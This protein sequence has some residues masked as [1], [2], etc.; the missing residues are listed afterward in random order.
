GR[1]GTGR[2]GVA[3]SQPSRPGIAIILPGRPGLAEQSQR[4]GIQQVGEAIAEATRSGPP[5]PTGPEA[6]V[7]RADKLV[8]QGKPEEAV[9]I[10][11]KVLDS[12]PE[13]ISANMGLG[14]AYIKMGEFDSAVN[15]FQKA[16]DYS[17]GNA[18]AKLN[19]GVALY[20]S[21]RIQDAIDEYEKSLAERKG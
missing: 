8:E 15:Q 7:D 14:Y 9:P 13:L 4:L 3:T 17:P 18:E 2:P 5:K 6:I 20:R 1:P 10:Y 11:R 19:L 12:N 21:G 16:V